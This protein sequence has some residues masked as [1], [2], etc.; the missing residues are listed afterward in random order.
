MVAGGFRCALSNDAHLDVGLSF[1]LTDDLL[2]WLVVAS[3][4]REAKCLFCHEDNVEV[5]IRFA[6]NAIEDDLAVEAQKLIRSSCDLHLELDVYRDALIAF[7]EDAV[8]ALIEVVEKNHQPA[9]LEAARALSA[10]GDTRAIP[11]LIKILDEDSALMEHW[12]GQ[13]LEKMGVG[14]VFFNP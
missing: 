1:V 3:Q 2:R 13:G 9:R 12:A 11:V 10:I 8:P 4:F 14:M 6:L 7:G 5:R